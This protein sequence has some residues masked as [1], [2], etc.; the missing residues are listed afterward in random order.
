MPH[1]ITDQNTCKG[2]VLACDVGD[3]WCASG[4]Q[5][6]EFVGADGYADDT[7]GCHVSAF[8]A[9]VMIAAVTPMGMAR[10]TRPKRTAHHRSAFTA[11]HALE[12]SESGERVLK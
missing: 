6:K 12:P 7:F 9:A 1:N 2:R 8:N 10:T 11:L 5:C 3:G 4:G